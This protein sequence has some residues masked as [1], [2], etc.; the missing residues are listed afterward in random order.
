MRT[1]FRNFMGDED[2]GL[3]SEAEARLLSVVEVTNGV[4]LKN[5]VST[6]DL[7]VAFIEYFANSTTV[8][9]CDFVAFQVNVNSQ[10]VEKE[11]IFN[12]L[13]TKGSKVVFR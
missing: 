3:L 8:R 12:T 10:G 9:L 13:L 11:A 5:A 1:G 7:K 6:A 2:H 4:R